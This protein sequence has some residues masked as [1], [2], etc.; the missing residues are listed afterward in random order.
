MKTSLYFFS[1]N[2]F[3]VISLMFCLVLLSQTQAQNLLKN[4]QVNPLSNIFESGNGNTSKLGLGL[5]TPIAK[6]HI[7]K[8][9]NE[10][11]IQGGLKVDLVQYR[12]Q[13]LV[14]IGSFA[15][16]NRIN[17]KYFG[18]YQNGA[19]EWENHLYNRVDIGFLDPQN[20]TNYMLT[21][22]GQIDLKESLHFSRN[23]QHIHRIAIDNQSSDEDFVFTFL[24]PYMGLSEPLILDP[25]VGVISHGVL[26]AD[27]FRL[28]DGAGGEKVLVSD[29]E[30]YGIWTD[31]SSV[32]DD[33]WLSSYQHGDG[34]PK[35]LY[36]GPNY[37]NVG[38]GT[39]NPLNMLHVMGGNILIS[40]DPDEAPGSLNGSIYFGEIVSNDYPNGE[41]GIEY[42]IDGL[43][44]WKVTSATNPGANHCLFLK[45][46]GN[47]GIGTEN[48][49]SKFQINRNFEKFSVGS[50]S[51]MTPI[52]GTSYLG[53]N[54]ARDE[55]DLWTLDPN[56]DLS[57]NGGSVIL[58]DM[59]GNTHFSCIPS[60]E[61]GSGSEPQVISDETMINNIKATLTSTGRFGIGTTQ[62]RGYLNVRKDGVTDAIIES[63]D[64]SYATLWTGNTIQHY[65]FGID[66]HGVGHIFA[67]LLFRYPMISFTSLNE[68]KVGIGDVDISTI[69]STH[70]LFV[71][72]GITT[73]E[74]T[75]KL[76]EEWSDYVLQPEYALMP[77]EKLNTYIKE[78]QHLPEIP[79][80]EEVHKNGVE[81]GQMNALI[82][83]KIEELTLYVIE[84]KSELNALKSAVN[85]KP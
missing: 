78:H 73:E 57:K 67:H 32:H 33:D 49:V 1:F 77:L 61:V 39:D 42:Y 55:R 13:Q 47:V 80:A 82:M 85:N 21:V 64:P 46:D 45:N 10:E 31:A 65:G 37:M 23:N 9:I 60:L 36:R 17:D 84:L 8:E 79:T 24:N 44:F 41:W 7:Q 5:T 56:P 38:I 34:P 6:F 16:C 30:G 19:P 4:D 63:N 26:Q 25:M 11:L 12:F 51:T 75:V 54:A 76:K 2:S 68:G 62:P 20:Q 18:I 15:S 71:E 28:L 69:T 59:D 66:D 35:N 40:R 14:T 72:N 48:P 52:Q 22:N 50:L 43:N 83:K 81:L 53:F 74:V 58:S 27:R 70:K 3:Q 29:P